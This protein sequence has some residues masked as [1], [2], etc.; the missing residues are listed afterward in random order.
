LW[1]LL[2]SSHA[3]AAEG[4]G[5]LA[6]WTFD[7]P[8]A[9]PPWRANG[10]V[11][12]LRIIDGALCCETSGS[13]PI[14]ELSAALDLK[15]SPRQ[16]IEMR[17]QADREGAAEVFW[18]GTT[19][20][21]Y[22]GFSEDKRTPFEVAAGGWRTYRLLP[23]WHSEGRIVRLRL[24]LFGG[25]RFRIDFIR[26]VELPAAEPPPQPQF[27]FSRGP[28]GWLPVGDLRAAAGN[29]GVDLSAA[30]REA[31]WLSPPL[32]V[33]A[34]DRSCVV[35]RLAA[36]RDG[37]A[38][39][40][41]L[42]DRSRGLHSL[43]FP[44]AGGGR[45]RHYNLDMLAAKEWRDKVIALGFKPG[46]RMRLRSL[47]V[48]LEPQGPPQLKIAAL[49]PTEA[50]PRA[51]RPFGLAALVANTGAGLAG[52]LR[53]TLE[54]PPGLEI[55]SEP[56]PAE[57]KAS[58]SHGDETA[59]RWTL[60][61]TAP[62]SG[63]VTAQ[64][65]APGA[66]AAQAQATVRVSPR[67]AAGSGAMPEPQPA[68]GPW[69][70]GVYYFPGW[71]TASRWHPIQRFPERTP[72]LGWYREG[73][74]EVADWHIKW[75]VEHGITYFA[76]D[77]Y[78]SKGARQLEHGL[79]D[80][81]FRARHRH[82]LKFC[83]LWANHNPPGTHSLA[84]CREV[85]RYWIEHYF[86]RPEYYRVGGRPLVI[87]FS[88]YNLTTDLSPAGVRQGFEAMREE[89][90]KAGVP[91]VFLAAC[92]GGAHNLAAEGY[93]AITA[94]NWPNLGVVSTARRAPYSTL[95]DGYLRQWERLRD[96]SPL[97]LLLPVNG[98]WDSRPWHGDSALV[99]FDRTPELFRRHLE[100][101]RRLL[102]TGPGRT[103]LLPGV[104]IEAWNEW[105]EG[106]Y[107][108]PHLE[109]GFEY[110]DAIREVFARAPAAHQDLTPA[111]VGLGPYDV[112]E[113]RPPEPV[114]T[115]DGGLEGWDSSM[116]FGPL[117]ATNGAWAGVTSG[118]DP[119]LFGP[120]MQARAA[121]FQR[122]LLRM[123]LT[124]LEAGPLRDSAQLFWATRRWP[125]SEASS[126]RF[127]VALDG[128]WHDCELT[129]SANRR[130]TGVVTRLRL[131]PCSRPAIRVEVD[132]LRLAP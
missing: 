66:D 49:A 1:I 39:V 117:G 33:N 12:N 94:Y 20:G 124:P 40:C 61:A 110:L 120:P 71:N 95:I 91:E 35:L 129:V 32:D 13:D 128:Q 46:G 7:R 121:S 30:D 81:Y 104:L 42:T 97:P 31:L 109:Y 84:D 115:F 43:S 23:G 44:V 116:H 82:L 62:L 9:P 132:A 34:L 24:D 131:D 103:N 55:L 88:P 105:G 101:A 65:A 106:S 56:S 68:R 64:I 77:W 57:G 47:G 72:A 98:G 92:V 17:L 45:E 102:E 69:E 89:C 122:V 113:Q 41:F 112:P 36:E 126:V 73:D 52:P 86:R 53:A 83:L 80:G 38:E 90:R 78:W 4:P 118:S 114:W 18:S 67:P 74:P 11:Q 127:P 108:E 25:A 28:E 70:V 3:Q 19:Q 107:I 75:A 125:E 58:L 93:D 5:V 51:G 99:R 79:H 130:W 29:A 26:I 59:L 123:R 6:E 50:L 16:A 15:A 10:H 96:L 87:L 21:R 54:T 27:D 37:V 14:L 85:A 60:R 48:A 119:A 63:R 100:D 111:D 8:E 22:G 2:G 76:Y